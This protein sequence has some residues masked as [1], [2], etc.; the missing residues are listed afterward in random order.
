MLLSVFMAGQ[1]AGC[2]RFPLSLDHSDVQSRYSPKPVVELSAFMAQGRIVSAY[3][4]HS[5]GR[6]MLHLV[7]LQNARQ[8]IPD[9]DITWVLSLG[10]PEQIQFSPASYESFDTS[11]DVFQDGRIVVVPLPGVDGN[12]VGVFVNLLSGDRYFFAPAT[13]SD[14]S[15]A[16]LRSLSNTRPGLKVI[17]AEDRR[18]GEIVAG[19]P[20]FQR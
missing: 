19:F 7:D 20:E 11:M 4:R 14:E 6:I 3:I 18:A 13:V 5:K 17:L 9:D 10:S 1:L 2:V 8:E 15:R 16:K 12:A